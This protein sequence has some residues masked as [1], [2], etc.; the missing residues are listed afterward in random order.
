[1][2]IVATQ[3]KDKRLDSWPVGLY[4]RASSFRFR[5]H[6]NGQRIIEV[7]GDIPESDAIR[8]ATRYNLDLEDGIVPFE[9][10]SKTETVERFARDIWLKKKASEV[11]PKS[12]TRYRAVVD[13]FL[14]YLRIK[15][16]LEVSLSSITYEIASDF[17]VHRAD[18]PLMPNGHKKFTRALRDGASK[19]TLHYEREILFQMFKEAVKRELIKHNPFAD[20][21][22]K[23]PSRQEVASAHHPLSVEEENRLLNAAR[24][25]D[26]GKADDDNPAFRDIVFFLVRTGLRED[27]MR[28]LEWTDIDWAEG[29]IHVRQKI[30]HETRTISIPKSAVAGLKRRLKGKMASDPVFEDK[31]DIESFGVRLNIRGVQALLAL[32][33]SDVD[34]PNLRITTNMSYSWK[35]KGT[36]GV[37][38]M[39]SAVRELLDELFKCRTSNFVFAHRDGGACRVDI[40]SLL[41]IAQKKAGIKGR[42]RV[43]DLRHTL[44]IRLRRDKGVALETIMGILRHADIRETLIYAPY[45]LQEGRSAI[46]KLDEPTAPKNAVQTP[47]SSEPPPPAVLAG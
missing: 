15:G 16:L 43:H 14:E 42:L 23:K 6:Y 22:P 39:C 17:I 20:V 37:V 8:R 25:L 11:R 45:S 31:D 36:N 19:K 33:V 3:F 18:T 26:S 35:P 29:L 32:K 46:N 28:N 12:L 4:R 1:M 27:E 30:V 41:K 10:K 9:I 13:N 7:W 34:L 2:T 38:P 21:R 47:P 5:R 24:E 44:A 40:L